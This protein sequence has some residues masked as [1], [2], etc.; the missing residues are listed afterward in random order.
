MLFRSG[1]R[2]GMR[3]PNGRHDSENKSQSIDSGHFA[4][5]RCAPTPNGARDTGRPAD[6]VV[7]FPARCFAL[8]RSIDSVCF[9]SPL[10]PPLPLR[11]T[12]SAPLC[13]PHA[14]AHALLSLTQDG[15]ILSV[16]PS[17]RTHTRAHARAR[18]HTHINN[19]NGNHKGKRVIDAKF[20]LGSELYKFGAD[21]REEWPLLKLS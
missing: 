1:L 5:L 2:L 16:S 15:S 6:F 10:V 11:D 13:A 19:H 7:E 12:C 4:D 18:I 9:V 3:H 21:W 17:A 20:S 14:R 8:F